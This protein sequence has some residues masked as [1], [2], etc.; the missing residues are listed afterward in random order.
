MNVAAVSYDT[1]EIL[2]HFSKRVGGIS[3]PLLA[4]PDAKMIRA[5][6][7][8][9][10]NI[11]A[12]SADFGMARPGTFVVDERGVVKSK[13][14]EPGHRQRVTAESEG[15]VAP[16]VGQYEEDVRVLGGHMSEPGRSSQCI[17]E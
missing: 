9:N 12:E 5:F 2:D 14:F 15:V 16:L 11:E 17:A 8:L 4:D 10:R 7:V 3:Y 13:Y 6:G 1:Q